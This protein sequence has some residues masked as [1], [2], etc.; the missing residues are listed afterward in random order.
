MRD[1]KNRYHFTSKEGDENKT[2]KRRGTK[3]RKSRADKREIRRIRKI[4]TR[5]CWKR[6]KR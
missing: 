4:E 5:K 6:G 1:G 2:I 3:N